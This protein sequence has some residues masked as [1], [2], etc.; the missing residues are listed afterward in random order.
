MRLSTT[1]DHVFDFSRI[2]LGRLAQDVLDAMRGQVIGTRQ[3]E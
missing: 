2:K 1:E 3:V